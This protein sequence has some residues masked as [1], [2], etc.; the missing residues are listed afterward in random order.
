MLQNLFSPFWCQI[1]K[2]FRFKVRR[3]SGTARFSVIR[4]QSKLDEKGCLGAPDLIVE[5]LSPSNSQLEL[6][7]KYELYQ[8]FGVKE[9]WIIHPVENTLQINLLIDGFY[10]PSWLF[11]SGQKVTSPVLHDLWKLL[12]FPVFGFHFSLRDWQIGFGHWKNCGNP[13][14]ITFLFFK[15]NREK[16]IKA[17]FWVQSGKNEQEGADDPF[18]HPFIFVYVLSE[19]LPE[20]GS[21]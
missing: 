6:Q 5:I 15:I 18:F 3:F 9:Y 2:R 11:N 10:Q 16:G 14:P 13:F 1:F 4:D 7:N 12:N 19:G 21:M 17:P 8:E 20:V